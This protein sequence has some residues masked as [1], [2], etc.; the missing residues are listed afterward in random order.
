MISFIVFMA[1]PR[2]MRHLQH[3]P[4]FTITTTASVRPQV[5]RLQLIFSMAVTIR[6]RLI[7]GL[8]SD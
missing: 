8:E 7:R 2:T 5:N 4:E 6:T 1:M 3:R